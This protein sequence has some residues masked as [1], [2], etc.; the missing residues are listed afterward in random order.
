MAIRPFYQA[1][2]AIRSRPLRLPSRLR[3]RR[4]HLVQ[5]ATD[6][7]HHPS[8]LG[9]PV[10]FLFL[11]PLRLNLLVS[12][13]G[14]PLR[15]VF[16]VQDPDRRTAFFQI[17]DLCGETFI[18]YGTQGLISNVSGPLNRRPIVAGKVIL[19]IFIHHQQVNMPKPEIP[20]N[21]HIR[22]ESLSI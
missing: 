17:G 14:F 20:R 10:L 16:R 15:N 12:G 13:G 6:L 1:I 22:R 19:G 21:Q 18:H 3:G 5:N 7:F 2:V 11:H 9:K 8:R 4:H